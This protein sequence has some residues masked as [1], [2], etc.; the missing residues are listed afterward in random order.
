M[1]DK[2]LKFYLNRGYR[3][4]QTSIKS[5]A[6]LE[7]IS[8]EKLDEIT[9]RQMNQI[10]TP[11]QIS[12]RLSK[13]DINFIYPVKS[14]FLDGTINQLKIKTIAEF[15]EE[16][17]KR[18]NFEF[19]KN[20]WE[21]LKIS[22]NYTFLSNIGIKEIEEYMSADKIPIVLINYDIFVG[23]EN[24]KNG[25]YLII[26][27]IDKEMVTVSD[28]GPKNASPN[29]LMSRTRLENSLMQTPLD[30]GIVFV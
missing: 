20:A 29:K 26:R 6:T 28:C 11:L 30:Y 24:K 27:E 18:T 17:Y 1:K 14:F 7:D 9:G 3:C 15:E 2:E 25:H 22:N 13:I 12:Y 21:E 4:A 5:V 10:T 19:I 8:F 23:R 16:T